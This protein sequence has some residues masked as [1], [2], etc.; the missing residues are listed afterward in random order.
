MWPVEAAEV[1]KAGLSLTELVGVGPSNVRKILRWFDSPP[2]AEPPP[3]RQEFLTL[4]QARK[5]LA[6]NPK[7]KKQLKGDLQMHTQWSDGEGT[8]EDMATEALE[9]GYQYIGITDHTKGL[10]IAGGLDE[11]RLQNQA[12]EIAALVI[13]SFYPV[14]AGVKPLAR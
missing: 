14:S 2:K 13:F 5:I 7:W 8:I 6:K 4:A 12:K 11:L 9:R 1:V 10:K 3:K